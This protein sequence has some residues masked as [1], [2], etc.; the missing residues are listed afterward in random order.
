[1][2]CPC[3]ITPRSAGGAL[4]RRNQ[5]LHVKLPKRTGS[6]VPI[7]LIVDSTGLKICGE[8]EWH[9]KKH[10]AKLRRKWKKLHIGVD[11]GGWIHTSSLTDGHTQDPTVVAQL[12]EAVDR[13][14][15]RF[16]A[17]GMY[18]NA[19]VYDALADHQ[20]GVAIDIVVPPRRNATP[21]QTAW[22][23]PTQRDQHL[24]AIQSEGICQWRRASGYYAQSHVENAFS[25]Y[26]AMFGGHLRSKNVESQQREALMGCDILNRL[27]DLGRPTSVPIP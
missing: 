25:R 12:L 26:K 4:S 16:I 5:T 14:L 7:T 15:E 23:T 20:D 11:D 3:P 17:D 10:G 8:G 21:S 2:T 13:P 19:T 22:S 27:R 18:D 1:M 9:S 6:T 24:A